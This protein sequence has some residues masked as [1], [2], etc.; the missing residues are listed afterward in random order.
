MLN[1]AYLHACNMYYPD[2]WQQAGSAKSLQIR[3][4]LD[5]PNLQ[6]LDD[7][8]KTISVTLR[9]VCSE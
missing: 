4:K 7:P 9:R 5:D 6:L 3:S 8:M 2:L 1:G